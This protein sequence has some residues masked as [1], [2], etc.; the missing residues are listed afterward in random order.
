VSANK[1][2]VVTGSSSGLGSEV[3]RLLTSEGYEVVGVARRDVDTSDIGAGY[4]HH[5]FDFA[6]LDGIKA[7]TERIVAKHG[8]PYALINCAAVGADGVLP[9]MHA[10]EIASTIAVN[11]TAPITLTKYLS[12][13]ML[14]ARAGRIVNITSVVASTGYRGLSVYASTKAG[15]EGFSRSLARDIGRRGVTV[16]CVAPGFMDTAMTESLGEDALASIKRR[17]ALGRLAET[18]SVAAMVSF[19]L[20]PAGADISGSIFTVDAGNTA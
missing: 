13:G 9:T 20:G 1:V 3:A 14:D 12:R 6:D 11:L 2:V 7:L 4:S 8:W 16:N 5:Q 15:M 18:S 19:L 17:S 10:S